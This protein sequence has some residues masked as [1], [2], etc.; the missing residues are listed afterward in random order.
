M[1]ALSHSFK[2]VSGNKLQSSS[3]ADKGVIIQARGRVRKNANVS[4][5]VMDLVSVIANIT[6]SCVVFYDPF[7]RIFS[8]IHKAWSA[9]SLESWALLCF[10][11]QGHL[12]DFQGQATGKVACISRQDFA[13]HPESTSGTWHVLVL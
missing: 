10:S 11:S 8:A 4:I 6:S 5:F 9:K 3:K 13:I 12:P 1:P 2:L 7:V